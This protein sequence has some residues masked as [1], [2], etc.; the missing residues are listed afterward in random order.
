MKKSFKRMTNFYAQYKP[1]VISLAVAL[2]LLIRESQ[3]PLLWN[4]AIMKSL[5]CYSNDVVAEFLRNIIIS[6]IA[7]IIFFYIVNYYADYKREEKAKN[8][9]E[10]FIIN[11]YC[12]CNKLAAMIDLGK[13]IQGV[14][15]YSDIKFGPDDIIYY[16]HGL[17]SKGLSKTKENWDIACAEAAK[18]ISR[19][20]ETLFG[21]PMVCWLDE[22]VMTDLSKLAADDCLRFNIST[23]ARLPNS[24]KYGLKELYDIIQITIKDIAIYYGYEQYRYLLMDKKEIDEYDNLVK[25]YENELK[26]LP[27]G[28]IRYVDGYELRLS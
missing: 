17:G 16:K 11:I 22:L 5:F 4:N 13:E 18:C 25:I 14:T 8:E 2:L 19:E 26:S 23:E 3:L 20:C 9:L 12:Y 7:A 27:T 28:V 24:M 15:E 6:Y 21:F 10:P 1:L